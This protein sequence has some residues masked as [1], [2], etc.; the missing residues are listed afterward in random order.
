MQLMTFNGQPK[1][2][3]ENLSKSND[4]HSDL[5]EI[6]PFDFFLELATCFDKSPKPFELVQGVNSTVIAY[7]KGQSKK[8]AQKSELLQHTGTHL[9]KAG[10]AARQL[11]Y[12]LKQI[13][14]SAITEFVLYR[15][16]A[17]FLKT[18]NKRGK[19]AYERA[20][21]RN[22]PHDPF[23]YLR[24]LSNALSLTVNEI[25]E[26]PDKNETEYNTAWRAA[27]FV[28]ETNAARKKGKEKLPAHYAL[29]M[30]AIAFRPTWERYSTKLYSKGRY[31][32]DR[33][34][35][36][37]EPTRAFH[38]IIA[39]IDSCVPESLAGTAIENIR[40]HSKVD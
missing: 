10:V 36:A 30:A 39:K 24:E 17:K 19:N 8:T 15:N 38:K 14:K 18:E 29:E 3:W 21:F 1:E 34:G 13:S 32:H 25:I 31:H 2:I 26:L 5:A 23:A 33:G 16:T 11:Q 28:R 35:Y 27:E 6:Y 9:I 12:S 37:S 40:N 7:L 4:I 20:E 22:G